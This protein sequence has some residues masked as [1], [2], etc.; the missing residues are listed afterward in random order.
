MNKLEEL[1][2]TAAKLQQQIEELEKPKKW[3]P[4]LNWYPDAH[5][6]RTHHR[7][8]T[9]VYEFDYG[10]YADW[11]SRDQ[12]KYYVSYNIHQQIYATQVVYICRHICA[13]YMSKQ[14]AEGLVVKLNS[15]EVIL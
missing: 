11:S 8:L 14:C 10:W 3:E 13:V 4:L 9:Y 15:G 2:A 12:F 6:V 1:K 7:L 5:T